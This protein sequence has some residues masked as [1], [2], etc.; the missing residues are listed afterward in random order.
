[1][2][3][4]YRLKVLANT[5]ASPEALAEAIIAD[6]RLT[7]AMLISAI[8]EG[9][10]WWK[11]IIFELRLSIITRCQLDAEAVTLLEC[12]AL[13]LAQEVVGEWITQHEYAEVEA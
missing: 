3:E 9:A 12:A 11:E 6:Q 4:W 13:R 10:E 2:N 5:L 8:N 7:Q 1:M